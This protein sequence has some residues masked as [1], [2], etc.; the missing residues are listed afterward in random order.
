[1]WIFGRT[2][3]QAEGTAG[4][5]SRLEQSGQEEESSRKKSQRDEGEQAH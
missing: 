4:A 5:D 1:M 2:A 3:F